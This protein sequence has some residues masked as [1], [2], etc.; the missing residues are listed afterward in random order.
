MDKFKKFCKKPLLI[1]SLSMV[2]VFLVAL[3]VM[4]C[5]PKGKTYVCKYE[6]DKVQYTYTIKL[7]E[8]FVETHTYTDEKG[9]VLNVKTTKNQEYDYQVNNKELFLVDSVTEE[10][11]K[12]GEINSRKLVLNYNIEKNAENTVLYCSVNRVLTNVFIVG[13]YFGIFLLSICIVVN[14]I[15]K[16]QDLQKEKAKNIAEVQKEMQEK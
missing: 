13:L 16:Q 4:L 12:I 11:V 15:H 1:I 8:K 3:L 5:I 10:K 7:G 9:N 2:V 6:V 14:Y